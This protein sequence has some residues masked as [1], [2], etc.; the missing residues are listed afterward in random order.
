MRWADTGLKGVLNS[1]KNVAVQCDFDGTITE[2]EVSIL[3]L[4]RFAEGDWKQWDDDFYQG[5]MSVK[6]CTKRCFALVETDERTM[7]DFVLNSGH[8][9]VRD[10]FAEFRDYCKKK[11][12]PFH[13][14]SNGLVF[15]I[16][17]VLNKIG[18]SDTEIIAAQNRFSPGGM[19]VEFPGPDGKES[20]IDLKE[21]Y[22]LHLREKGYDVVCIG[23]SVSDIP[24]ARHAAC[25]FATGALQG[26]CRRENINYLP[27]DS[28]HDIIRGLEGLT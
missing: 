20:D 6:E 4:E 15:Y 11:D 7:T 9:R 14:V 2:E 12:F 26:H 17:A 25:V 21:Q 18:I 23:D 22:I 28:F 8:V 10:G 1:L 13:V 16:E 24:A 27:F 19:T 5:R 3:L